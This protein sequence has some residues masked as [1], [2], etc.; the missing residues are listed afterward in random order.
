[1]SHDHDHHDHDHGHDHGHGAH[2][3]GAPHV[4]A[5]QNFGPAFVIG[6]ALNVAFVVAE[7]IAGWLGNSV[8]LLA[9]AGH[10][11]GDVLGLAVAG[12]AM[13]LSTRLPTR[14]FT[15][16]LGGT[17]ILA[18]LFNAVLL[19]VA[20][21]GIGW[22]A[23]LRLMHPEPAAGLVVIVV[24]AIGIAVNGGTALLFAAGRRGDLNVR[25]AFLHMLADAAVSAAV[26]IAG[27]LML[28][29][30]WLWLD[31]LAS[32]IVCAVIIWSSWSL[33]RESIAMS[34][35]AVPPHIDPDAVRLYLAAL[36][37]VGDVHDLHIWPMSTTGIALT[38]HLKMRSGH[39]G[40]AF[41]QETAHELEHRFGIAHP[42]LQI[43]VD[44]QSACELAPQEVV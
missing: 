22:E 23:I 29:T 33:L 10:N 25:G 21:G 37:D 39:P 13:L 4:H 26:V 2:D 8:A 38:A 19:L 40:D 15:Y 20:V 30:G 41:L 1:M 14:R 18:A 27:L 7:A 6:I 44:P 36:P 9:D 28:L 43:E 5:P 12:I 35:D 11:F 34:L 17:S 31:P 3:H 16:G 32:L 24:A 42:T